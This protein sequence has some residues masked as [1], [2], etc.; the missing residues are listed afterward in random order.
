VNYV[1]IKSA[2]ILNGDINDLPIN[3]DLL[4]DEIGNFRRLSRAEKMWLYCARVMYEDFEIFVHKI[5]IKNKVKDT[6]TYVNEGTPPSYHENFNCP[7]FK[8]DYENELLP[9]EIRNKDEEVVNDFREWY[10]NII[11]YSGRDYSHLSKEAGAKFGVKIIFP[12]SKE[13]KFNSGEEQI[14]NKS[15]SEIKEKVDELVNKALQ[16]YSSS[17]NSRKIIDKYGIR[18]H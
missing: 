11:R 3:K 6:L 16:F 12:L 5:Y 13:K 10:K 15:P 9:K 1:D 18:S 8:S 14:I 7:N 17:S 4:N 2:K